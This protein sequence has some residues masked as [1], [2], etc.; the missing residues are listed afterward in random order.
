MGIVVG[1]TD[2][3]ALAC[4]RAAAPSLWFLC[5]GVGAQG[6]N[7]KAALGAGLRSDG[8]GMLVSVSRSIACDSDPAGASANLRQGINDVRRASAST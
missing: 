3:Y 8:M 7:L 6:A 2:P 1:A 4:V 5:P